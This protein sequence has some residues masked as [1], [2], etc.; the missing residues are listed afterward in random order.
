MNKVKTFR[1]D[2]KIII[3][4][5]MPVILSQISLTMVQVVDTIFIGRLGH[6]ALGAVSLVITLFWML[7]TLGLGF[8][9]GITAS[10]ARMIGKG[11]E[12]SASLFFRSGTAGI[13]LLGLFCVP[14]LFFFHNQI[15]TLIRMPE[16]LFHP[17]S[18]YFTTLIFFLPVLYMLTSTEAAFRASGD[19]KT[20]MVISFF[21]NGLNILLNWLLIF[22][23]LGFPKLGIIGAALAS[24]ISYS[25][26]LAILIFL[27]GKRSW[28]LRGLG[29]KGIS[30]S[31]NHLWGII[32]ISI[33]ATLERLAMSVSQL[34]V[35]VTSVNILGSIHVAAFHIIFRLASLSFM[36]GFGFA[37]AT[38]TIT[39]QYLGAEEPDRAHKGI[40]QSTI[41]CA[42][43]M[44]GVSLLYFLIPGPLTSLFTNEP[45]ILELTP[46]PIRIYALMAVFLAPTMVLGGGLRGAGDTG[47]PMIIMFISRF[48][49][50]VPF[51][52]FLGIHLGMG[53]KGVWFAMCF[54]FLFRAILLAFRVQGGKWKNIRI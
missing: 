44:A 45:A 34:L 51:S 24:G 22:G 7:Q 49:I 25:L 12:K 36:P 3:R 47:Y 31:L 48:L 28:G 9:T 29:M 19:T 30:I 10:I 52:W 15:F 23:N 46:E 53:L 1:S 43:V 5:A 38:S 6:E 50:R 16:D 13:T 18:L 2:S 33:P 37:I 40:W 27:S 35:M 41:L 8:A 21:M 14:P 26:G 54:D 17:A 39:G 11:D 32:R 4:L 42:F 20:P